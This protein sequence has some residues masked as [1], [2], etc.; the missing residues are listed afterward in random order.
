MFELPSHTLLSSLHKVASQPKEYLADLCC[1]FS[2]AELWVH[3]GNSRKASNYF[4][5]STK[6][7]FLLPYLAILLSRCPPIFLQHFIPEV[8]N[9]HNSTNSQQCIVNMD[10]RLLSSSLFKVLVDFWYTAGLD[11]MVLMPSHL[12]TQLDT[13]EQEIGVSLLPRSQGGNNDD[14]SKACIQQES[15]TQLLNDLH[16][17]RHDGLGC[18]I[19]LSLPP[20]TENLHNNNLLIPAHRFILASQS[21]YFYAMFCMDFCESQN[22]VVHLIDS[23]FTPTVTQ[24]MLDYLYS[25]SVTIPPP[26]QLVSHSGALNK[27]QKLTMK[28]HTLRVLQMVFAAAD[29]LGQM[30][31]LGLAVLHEMAQTCDGFKCLCHDCVLLLPSMLFFTDKKRDDP[32]LG[33][34]RSA[35][36]TLYSDPV[37]AIEHLWSQKPFA[38]L[39][40]FM[41]PSAASLMKSLDPSIT[42]DEWHKPRSTLIFEISDLTYTNVTKHN[43]I[44]VLHSLHLCFSKLRSADLMPTWSL[45]TL[46]LLDPILRSTVAMVSNHFDF[47]CVEYPILVSCVD[48]I[49]CGFSIDF[50]DFLLKRVLDQGIRDSNAGIIYQGIV[51]DLIGRQETVKNMALDDVLLNARIN[52]TD[53]LTRRW[54]SVRSSGGFRYLDKP[55]MR[56]LCVGMYSI[57]TCTQYILTFWLSI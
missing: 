51:K 49:G 34:L 38:L 16:R 21:T 54:L 18:D 29:Y 11:A 5:L 26:P 25:E 35:L 39:V 57:Y 43:A 4:V 1:R 12:H 6:Y 22:K 8:L 44:H 15:H 37:H 53:Y 30:K 41:V 17:M 27:I 7:L 45:P 50:L 9:T 28:K 14:D 20:T 52:C 23:F 47:Y 55:T 3:K 2:D 31:T 48:G 56:Q 40:H 46:D 33:P 13:L 24:V 36:V 32:F 19:H 10:D 42:L